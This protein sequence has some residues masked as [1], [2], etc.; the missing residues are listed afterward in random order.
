[1][2]ERVDQVLTVKDGSEFSEKTERV[3]DVGDNLEVLIYVILKG[4]LY[5]RDVGLELNKVEVELDS[6]EI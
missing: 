3:V 6:V 1:M 2:L 5:S 4:S